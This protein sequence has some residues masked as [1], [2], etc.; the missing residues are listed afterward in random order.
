[1]KTI[2]RII[3][4]LEDAHLYNVCAKSINAYNYYQIKYKKIKEAI[5]LINLTKTNKVMYT[6]T[7]NTLYHNEICIYF[8]FI[9]TDSGKRYMF[10]I[11]NGIYK[12]GKIQNLLNT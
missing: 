10:H 5:E 7:Y 1:M 2:T 8:L 9:L 6:I 3:S 4:L 11:P 12:K